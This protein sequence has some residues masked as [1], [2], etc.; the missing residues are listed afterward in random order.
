MTLLSI[1]LENRAAENE[2]SKV[3][4]F[5]KWGEPEHELHPSSCLEWHAL[6]ELCS[7]EGGRLVYRSGWRDCDE[8][9]YKRAASD[10]SVEPAV[11]LAVH[12]AG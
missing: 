11:H 7:S 2:L 5:M 1:F 12:L 9:D 3:F 6:L 8:D 10:F 4:I